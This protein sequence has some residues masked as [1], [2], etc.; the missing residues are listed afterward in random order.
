MNQAA[1]MIG[2]SYGLTRLGPDGEV[3]VNSDLS[4]ALQ[5]IEGPLFRFSFA[6]MVLG[7]LRLLLIGGTEAAAAFLMAKD[8]REVWAKVGQRILWF[9]FPHLLLSPVAPKARGWGVYHALLSVFSLIFRLGAVIVP[10]F[11]V[12]HVYLW[13]RG[14]GVSWPALAPG[15]ADT[16][17]L[18]TIA[19]GLVVFLGRLYSPLLRKVEPVWSFLAPLILVTPFLTGV[20]A[21]HPTWS[22]LS[23]QTVLL[24]H[25]LTAC[26]VFVLLPFAHL[27]SFMHTP[28]TRWVPQA[29][30]RYSPP[31]PIAKPIPTPPMVHV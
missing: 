20:L 13:E 24:L 14:L 8:R 7:F 31:E 19:T 22:P 12:A 25:V 5:F 16:I 29:A 18:V 27:L 28:I 10:A 2:P 17:S 23:Y 1:H 6:L 11:M 26:T 15:A 30:W 3:F 21:M 9:L 4:S